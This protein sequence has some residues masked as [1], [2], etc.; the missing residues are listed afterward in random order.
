MLNNDRKICLIEET[1]HDPPYGPGSIRM[2]AVGQAPERAT[3]T[4]NRIGGVLAKR[5]IAVL[6]A[7][8]AG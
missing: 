2:L 6:V 4:M 3:G 8:E 1:A 7:L 5:L